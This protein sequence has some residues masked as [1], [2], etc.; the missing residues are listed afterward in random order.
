MQLESGMVDAVAC[1]LSIAAYQ[2]SAK[3][4]AF[5]QLDESLSSEHYAVGFKLG[6][7]A[8]A[9][10]VTDTLLEMYDD[11]T[12]AQICEKYASY[13]VDISNWVLVK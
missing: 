2:M 11:G 1:D 9:Q 12:V 7:D 3:P 13:G 4:D 8:I 5:I 6:D 10:I